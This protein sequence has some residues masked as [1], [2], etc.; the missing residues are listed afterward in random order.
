MKKNGE[1]KLPAQPLDSLGENPSKN[2]ID[3]TAM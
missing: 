2:K 3:A 1:K